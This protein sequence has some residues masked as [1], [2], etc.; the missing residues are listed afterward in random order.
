M[1]SQCDEDLLFD[2]IKV[3]KRSN[4]GDCDE[5]DI[6]NLDFR[7]DNNDDKPHCDKRNGKSKFQMEP[8][9]PVKRNYNQDTTDHLNLGSKISL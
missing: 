9:N 3:E 8:L 6:E 4:D 7:S 1:A 2:L 5:P